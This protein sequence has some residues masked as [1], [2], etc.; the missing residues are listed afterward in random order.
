MVLATSLLILIIY[1]PV[2]LFLCASVPSTFLSAHPISYYSYCEI[3]CDKSIE[4]QFMV[5]CFVHWCR[6]KICAD[7]LY[8][9]IFICLS[10]SPLFLCLY[11]IFK[12]FVHID[13]THETCPL[14][15]FRVHWNTKL[16]ITKGNGLRKLCDVHPPARG[17]FWVNRRHNYS[18]IVSWHS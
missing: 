13:D 14:K 8:S 12:R 5:C 3:S 4:K 10:D 16:N 1:R 2:Y 11:A 9:K 18:Y 6:Q 15:L 17:Q 7:F